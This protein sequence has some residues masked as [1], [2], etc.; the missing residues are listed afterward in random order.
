MSRKNKPLLAFFHPCNLFIWE[1]NRYDNISVSS[2]QI[3]FWEDNRSCKILAPFLQF[4]ISG[5]QEILQNIDSIPAIVFSGRRSDLVKSWLCPSNFLMWRKN[6]LNYGII[7]SIMA[8]FRDLTK[9]RH[10]PSNFFSGRR[11]D[12]VKSCQPPFNF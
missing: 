4:L 3:F 10:L 7:P 1:E 12:L 6:P 8:S 11:I 2:Q 5:G 9:S